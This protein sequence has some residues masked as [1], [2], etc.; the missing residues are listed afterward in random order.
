MKGRKMN[1]YV[2][3]V[4]AQTIKN[5][6]GQKYSD[7]PND[8]GG[9]TRFGITEQTARANGYTGDMRDLPESFAV[10]IA[11]EQF[12]YGPKFDKVAEFNAPL[13]E[14]MF[15]WGFMSGPSRPSK[16]LQRALNAMNRQQRDYAD[17]NAD[18]ALGKISLY[19]LGQFVKV[20]GQEGLRN[21]TEVVK[22]FQ[23]VLFIEIAEKDQSQE[24]FV[25]GWLNRVN[26]AKVPT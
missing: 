6:G 16:A 20:R 3:A 25:N 22:A 8:K 26:I 19:V 5:E 10:Q 1:Q 9:K 12:W 24:E 14:A 2:Q 11:T 17:I 4:I 7:N 13:A 18:G 23:R 15:D 21:L